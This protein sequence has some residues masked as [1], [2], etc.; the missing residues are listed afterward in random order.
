MPPS[1]T[2]SCPAT[3]K[4]S[5][6][7]R[8]GFFFGRSRGRHRRH[9]RCP[10]VS[11]F[12]QP[13]AHKDD[14]EAVFKLGPVLPAPLRYLQHL[15]QSLL[16]QDASR[17][18]ASPAGTERSFPQR[19]ATRKTPRARDQRSRAGSRSPT[20]AT[21]LPLHR[22]HRIP[23]N[24]DPTHPS[25][26]AR[27][28]AAGRAQPLPGETGQIR[29]GPGPRCRC[30]PGS[31]GCSGGPVRSAFSP[32]LREVMTPRSSVPTERPRPRSRTDCPHRRRR[33]GGASKAPGRWGN[34]SL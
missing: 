26:P 29:S 27:G 15:L 4:K 7:L 32:Y 28:G 5:L 33:P 14:F 12:F 20:G 9:T 19:G 24:P 34:P 11:F 31:R 8:N 6:K 18:Q 16:R 25:D 2:S 10:K 17:S 21:G 1:H 13:A 22:H 23:N 3:E 30:G